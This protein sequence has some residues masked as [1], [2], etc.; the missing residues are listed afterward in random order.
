M[1][2]EPLGA[3]PDGVEQ[4]VGLGCREDEYDVLRWLFECLEKS[5]PCGA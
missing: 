1:E 2:V 3:A 4:L 5:V